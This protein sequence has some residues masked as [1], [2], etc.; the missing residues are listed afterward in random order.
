MRKAFSYRTFVTMAETYTGSVYKLVH[1]PSSQL[2][3][4][5]TKQPLIKRYHVHMAAGFGPSATKYSTL[6]LYA[7]MST[8]DRSEWQ[9]VWVSEHAVRSKAELESHEFAYMQL[10]DQ[11]KLLNIQRELGKRAPSTLAKVN[12]VENGGLLSVEEY[13]RRCEAA[14]RALRSEADGGTMP[15]EQHQRVVETNSR[16]HRSVTDGGTMPVDQHQHLAE[17]HSYVERAK[18]KAIVY[19]NGIY[20]VSWRD[21]QQRYDVRAPGRHIRYFGGVHRSK[22]ESL[23]E[24]KELV[25]QQATAATTRAV[26]PAAQVQPVQPVIGFA[27]DL[28]HL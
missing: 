5:S 26:Q 15:V 12:S 1:L 16:S 20:Y 25:D 3:V 18:S 27:P 13:Q 11:S 4:G 23:R 22:E 2:Y 9:M 28:A 14:S 24:A 21:S 10:Q 19:E 8:T 7:F 17:K 6:P